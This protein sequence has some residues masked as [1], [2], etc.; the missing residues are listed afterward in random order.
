MVSYVQPLNWQKHAKNDS[1]GALELVYARNGSKKQLL[2]EKMRLIFEKW[3]L[4]KGYSLCKLVS[5]GQT[6]KLGKACEKQLYKH[7]RG[8]VC[9]KR[10]GKNS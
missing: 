6:I 1:T 3:P 7:I 9:V 8:F 4:C 10:L 2:F 5:L